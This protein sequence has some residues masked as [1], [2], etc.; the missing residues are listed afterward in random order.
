MSL[1]WASMALGV[2]LLALGVFLGL[3]GADGLLKFQ[4][5]LRA[6]WANLFFFGTA[7]VWFLIKILQLSEAD[8]GEYRHMLFLL[9]AVIGGLSFFVIPDF[10]AVRGMAVLTLL[11]AHVL[12]DAAFMQEP[13]SRLF[14]VSMVYVWIVAALY[15]GA[16]PYRLRDAVSG[17]Q[18]KPFITRLLAAFFGFYGLLLVGLSFTY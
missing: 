14:M 18:A 17:L 9:F 2:F 8:Y 5:T 16:L 6:R 7:L 13:A 4:K 12:L 10:L 1:F 11:W 15:L 3:S